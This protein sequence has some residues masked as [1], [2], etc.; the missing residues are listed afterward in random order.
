MVREAGEVSSS[1]SSCEVL[2]V[3]REEEASSASTMSPEFG[4]SGGRS[5]WGL[6][7]FFFLFAGA[8][9]FCFSELGEGGKTACWAGL[10][11]FFPLFFFPVIFV[12]CFFKRKGLFVLA[13]P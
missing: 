7:F 8:V 5:I 2:R 10:T 4:D 3:A 11:H 6:G 13:T 12:F 9:G 1:S